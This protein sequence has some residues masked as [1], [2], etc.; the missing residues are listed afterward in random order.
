VR[1]STNCRV[2]KCRRY[3]EVSYSPSSTSN[4]IYTGKYGF[5]KK[6]L[7]FIIKARNIIKTTYRPGFQF[8]ILKGQLKTTKKGPGAIAQMQSVTV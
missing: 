8:C 5:T 1:N 2:L 6:A 7:L 3:A 4:E